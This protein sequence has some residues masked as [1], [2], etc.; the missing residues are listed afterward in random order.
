MIIDGHQHF[1][2]A[3]R[4]DYHWMDPKAGL[5]LCRDYLPDD[6]APVLRRA[7]VDR[8]VLA[9][10][11]PRLDIAGTDRL[12]GANAARFYGLGDR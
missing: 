9:I 1:W 10:L 5:V 11:G 12:F 3:N 7:G 2:V 6:L 4:G 8:A